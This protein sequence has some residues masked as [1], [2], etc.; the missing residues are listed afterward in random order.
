MRGAFFVWR[1]DS[2]TTILDVKES[3]YPSFAVEKLTAK[4]P[5]SQLV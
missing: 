1:R 3:K 2:Q 5:S 4:R